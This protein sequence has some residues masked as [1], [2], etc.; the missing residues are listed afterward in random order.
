MEKIFEQSELESIAQALG[1]TSE[2]LTGAEIGH[3]L[4]SSNMADSYPTLTKWKRLYNAF[5][6][7]Q[8][9]SGIRRDVLQFIREAMKPERY[10]RA[11]ERY[12]PMRSNL[13]RALAFAG[14]AVEPSGELVAKERVN[15]LSEAK[16]AE[17]LRADLLAREVHPDVIKLCRDELI[18]DNYFHTS[19]PTCRC[20]WPPCGASNI[21]SPAAIRWSVYPT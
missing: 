1:D 8:N 4:A 11:P 10:A 9:F 3:I 20:R 2:G 19:S 16:R 14:P 7:R 18:A 5:A 12:E 15:T 21:T 13:N 6:E 17:E